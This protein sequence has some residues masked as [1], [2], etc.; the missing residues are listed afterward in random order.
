MRLALLTACTIRT[1]LLLLSALSFCIGSTL[2]TA[3]AADGVRL[4]AMTDEVRN[5]CQ[6]S[7][8]L[9]NAQRFNDAI[10]LLQRAGSIDP[11]CAEVHGYM[12][13]AYQNSGHANEAIAEYQQAL[14]LGAQ[15]MSFINVNIGNCY[16]NLDQPQRAVPYFQ[17][18]LRENPNAPDAAQVRQSIEN[19]GG[20]KNQ[21]DLRSVVEQGQSLLNN[22]QFAEAINAF[23]QAVS[24]KPNFAPAHFYL[25]YA[26]AQSGDNRRAISEFQTALQLDPSMKQAIVNIAS[27]Y[28]SLGDVNS[29]ITWYERYL[30]ENPG[31]PNAGDIRN[32]V[33]GLRQ[34]AQSQPLSGTM[35]SGNDYFMSVTPGGKCFRWSQQKMPIRVFIA[36]GTPAI[37][38]RDSF[39]QD[40]SDA[41]NEWSQA[42]DSRVTFVL[43]TDLQQSDIYCDWT[44][45][46]NRIVQSGTA[47]EGGLTK[48]TAQQTDNGPDV[49]ISRARMT[50]LTMGSGGPRN[51]NEMKKVCLHEIGHAIGLSGHSSSNQD[52]MFF[53]E[54]NS[55]W[56]VLSPRDKATVCRLYAGY[57]PAT[58]GP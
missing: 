45:D 58:N 36:Q 4:L 11:S 55:D 7:E 56:P 5:M 12:G 37:G 13:L 25:G 20:R 50:I 1:T 42:T 14:K 2:S 53:S 21:L 41:L 51:D 19:A 15:P 47:V 16:L 32:R 9:I 44:S 54:T 23:Q 34:Q 8:Q 49:R 31:A 43:V 26:L 3:R 40:L 57:P 46:P 6:Q 28:Q 27:D 22:H 18:Y 24:M 30:Q 33:K 10:K 48:L 17:Q 29:A 52:I 38:F 35:D 39:G